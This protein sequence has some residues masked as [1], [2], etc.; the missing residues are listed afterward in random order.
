KIYGKGRD[1][2]TKP[3]QFSSS[4][5]PCDVAKRKEFLCPQSLGPK[6]HETWAKASMAWAKTKKEKNPMPSVRHYF[7]PSHFNDSKQPNC[8]KWK[9]I[10]PSW[11]K[12]E[13]AVKSIPNCAIFY[14]VKE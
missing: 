1:I 11:A 2:I 14:N 8:G 9:G 7:F 12:K 6:W 4:T 3:G 5:G 10:Y 13:S